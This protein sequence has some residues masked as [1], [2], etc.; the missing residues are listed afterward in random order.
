MLSR[1]QKKY[2]ENIKNGVKL[3]VFGSR[4]LYNE[5]VRGILLNVIKQYKVSAIVT[6]S[7]IR[8]VCKLARELAEEKSLLLISVPIDKKKWGKGCYNVRSYLIASISDVIVAVWD[9]KS[10]GTK[11]EIELCKENGFDYGLYIVQQEWEEESFE[12]FED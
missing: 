1:R 12:W 5:E 11:G 10:R 7:K 6:A 4:S 3:G 2:V 8:G 9:G